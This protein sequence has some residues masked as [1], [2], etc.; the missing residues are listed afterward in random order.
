MDSRSVSVILHCINDFERIS[1]HAVNIIESAK[2][3]HDKKLS[4]SKNAMK[5]FEV[6]VE[7]VHKIVHMAVNAYADN[8]LEN[9]KVVEPLEQ[10]IN[11]LNAEMKQRH[12]RRLR[13]GKCTIELGWVLQDLLTNIERVSD[14]CSNIAICMIEVKDDEYDAHN[15]LENLKESN[16]RWYKHAMVAYSEQFKLP[17][18]VIDEEE[19]VV[20]II[21]NEKK[22]SS[23]N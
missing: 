6:Y 1:D 15:Y 20:S 9:A 17:E 21:K 2:E 19:S 22:E 16:I 13:K 18:S 11:G 7:A 8:D 5:E 4:F 23:K 3:M 10:V 14:H 12:I